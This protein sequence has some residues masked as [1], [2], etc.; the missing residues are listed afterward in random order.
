MPTKLYLVEAFKLVF[1]TLPV[2]GARLITGG[3]VALGLIAYA[4][5][6]L[7]LAAGAAALWE[8]LG[9]IVG[10][11]ALIGF[12]FLARWANINHL[13]MLKA[14]HAAVLTHRIRHGQAPEGLQVSYGRQRVRERFGN[15]E[16]LYRVDRKLSR[17]V[18]RFNRQFARGL[19]RLPI[20]GAKVL[21][22]VVGKFSRMMTQHIN[23]AILSRA[24]VQTDDDPWVVT[25]DGMVLYAQAWKP[26]FAN[27]LALGLLGIVEF[28]VLLVLLAIP[29]LTLSTVAS[30]PV[31]IG[32]AVAA[33]IIAYMLKVA[34]S[35]AFSLAATLL[36]FHHATEGVD[37]DPVWRERLD[38]A[39]NPFGDLVRKAGAAVAP[40]ASAASS[41]ETPLTS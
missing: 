28:I 16:A 26:V 40:H 30:L 1:Q 12:G 20:P 18:R 2:L 4:V 9:F 14:A 27:A 17:T 23:Q 24:Y 6:G 33:F 36:A 7:T 34:V 5:L 8:P 21:H 32:F 10:L 15:A 25:R 13:Y 37:P 38:Q 41:A 39:I 3:L 22:G 11:P 31:T 29:V 19:N 35:D